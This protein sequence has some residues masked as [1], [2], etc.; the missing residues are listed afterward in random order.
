MIRRI[1]ILLVALA[2]A[3]TTTVLTALPVSA[4]ARVSVSS[5]AGSGAASATGPTSLTVSGSGFQSIPRAFGGIYVFFGV[6]EGGSWRPSQGGASG[7][8]FR[9]I[10][11][12][13][14]KNNAG[15]QR[16]VAFPGSE[17]ADAAN[18]G[19]IAADG[20]WKTSLNVPG[21]VINV[22]GRT[23]STEQVDC[24][25]TTC[26]V[27]TVGAHGVKNAN[28][29]TF[30]PVK[31]VGGSSGSGNQGSGGNTGS[32]GSSSGSTTQATPGATPT[33][34]ATGDEVT[35]AAPQEVS[36]GIDRATAIAGRV[37]SFTARGFQPGEQVTVVLDDGLAAQ[38]PLV[39]GTQGEV[40]SVIQLPRDLRLGTHSMR[41]TGAAS[42]VIAQAEFVVSPPADALP[43]TETAVGAADTS[44]DWAWI[45]VAVAAA[46]LAMI[47]LAGLIGARRARKDAQTAAATRQRD[48]HLEALLEQARERGYAEVMDKQS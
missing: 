37:M 40:A 31:F 34:S 42:G 44:L 9:Y 22:I 29:E 47:L 46:V 32:T 39:A 33:T 28:N 26:G 18:G 30:T 36:L 19:E 41:V 38:G 4:A 20:T 17:T 11:D 21:P 13:E 23:G 7:R 16:F 10:P 6:V 24:R 43:A 12:S 1:S 15:F 25:T 2:T 14:S 8:T 27:I 48:E 3:L 35:A 45:A 5:S